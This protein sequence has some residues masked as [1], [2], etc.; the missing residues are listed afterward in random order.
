MPPHTVLTTHLKRAHD[1]DL[2]P[3]CPKCP[4]YRLRGSDVDKHALR[5][6]GIE[7]VSHKRGND[8]FRWGLVRLRKTYKEIGRASC[9]ERV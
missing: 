7:E 2:I 8:G 9:R 5:V 4:H 1:L 3:G 6:H